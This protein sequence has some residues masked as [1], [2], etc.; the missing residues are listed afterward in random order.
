MPTFVRRLLV[1]VALMFWLGGFTFYAGVVVPI[2]QQV[3]GRGPQSDVTRHVSVYLN[4][5]C[6]V[7][8][9]PLAW[10]VA[11]SGDP[12]RRRRICRWICV[13]NILASLAVL[14]WLHGELVSMMDQATASMDRGSSFRIGHKAYLWISTYQWLAGVVYTA[15]MVPA[16]RAEDKATVQVSGEQPGSGEK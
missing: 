10:D 5:A 15:L 7:A 6:A 12:S 16:W 3:L 8:L 14:H 2:G 13:A 4:L 9:V 1:L 11:G